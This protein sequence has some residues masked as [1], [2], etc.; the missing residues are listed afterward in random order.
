MRGLSPLLPVLSSLAIGCIWISSER[1]TERLDQ[2]SDGVP[3]PVDCNDADP[4]TSTLTPTGGFPPEGPE[5]P[6]P[7][8]D[9]AGPPAQ[10]TGLA[11]G[12]SAAGVFDLGCEPDDPRPVCSDVEPGPYEGVALLDVL[13]CRHPG[14]TDQLVQVGE[15][16]GIHRVEVSEPTDVQVFLTIDPTVSPDA[17]ASTE[18]HPYAALF[19]N[20]GR[21]CSEATCALGTPLLDAGV[22]ASTDPYVV[23][24]TAVPGEPWY[25]VASGPSGSYR[26]DVRCGEAEL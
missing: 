23:A 6:A 7:T 19:A 20:R 8:G 1:E 9:T 22:V 13:P 15:H 12:D 11:C 24:F 21:S 4:A 16:Q 26:L 18:L 25:V 17:G 5:E 2:D 3:L 14:L 10:G